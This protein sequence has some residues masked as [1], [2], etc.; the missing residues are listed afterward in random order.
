MADKDPS[1]TDGRK[2]H[3]SPAF[4]FF[5]KY[6]NIISI[7]GVFVL[8]FAFFSIQA[9][10]FL[11]AENLVNVGRQIAPT[12]IVATMMTLVITTGQID[13]SVGSIIGL[14]ASALAILIQTGSPIFGVVAALIIAVAAGAIQGLLAS[15][16]KLPAFIVTLAGLIALRGVALLITQGYSTPITVDWILWLGQ[17]EFLGI[18]M[19]TWI[20]L[21]TVIFG[22]YLFTQTRFGRYVVASGSNAEALRRSG[23]NVKRILATTLVLTGLFAGIA[24]VLIAARLATGSSNSGTLF[25]LEVITAVVLGGTSLLGGK[26]SVVGTLI[27]ALTLGIIANGLVLLRVDVFWVP[28]TQGV[29]LI[30]AMLLNQSA[31]DRF[32][33]RKA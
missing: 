19:P 21:A 11:T 18:Y 7:M 22:W 2:T 1:R 31:V 29:I 3:G 16:G 14:T 33:K 10:S 6:F 25:E 8:L 27:G 5:T 30:V 13:L 28:I 24:G 26:G 12:I 15:Y 20:A 4:E 23:V 17:G 9:D 32:S